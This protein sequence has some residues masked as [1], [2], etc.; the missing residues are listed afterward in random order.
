MG[1]AQLLCGQRKTAYGEEID[2]SSLAQLVSLFL[3]IV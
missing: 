3:P 2:M 1:I